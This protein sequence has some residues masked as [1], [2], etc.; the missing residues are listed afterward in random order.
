M[1]KGNQDLLAAL[2][3]GLAI[4]M[5]DGTF[6]ALHA[7]WFS[8]LE[9]VGRTKSRIVVGGDSDYPPYEFL[10]QNGQPSGYNVDLTRAIAQQMG[11]MVDIQLGTW[12]KTRKGLEAGISMWS[13]GRLFRRKG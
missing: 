12:G 7:K 8:T 5:A 10:D 11:L 13:K 3:E 2:N 1:R 6:R 4:V 9:A